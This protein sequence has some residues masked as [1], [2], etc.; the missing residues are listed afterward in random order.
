MEKCEMCG[1]ELKHRGALT[2]HMAFVHGVQPKRAPK[3][4]ELRD[5]V[6]KLR[7]DMDFFKQ[8]LRRVTFVEPDGSKEETL[9]G[10]DRNSG[11]NINLVQIID[12]EVIKE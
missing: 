1:K 2:G 10:W 11:K 12:A 3:L 7:A 8:F 9:A 6:D 5:E 4:D